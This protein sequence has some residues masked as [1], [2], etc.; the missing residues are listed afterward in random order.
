ML[1][2]LCPPLSS[3]VHSIGR[4]RFVG[5]AAELAQRLV[6]DVC[7]D[8]YE[9]V[10]RGSQVQKVVAVVGLRLRRIELLMGSERRVYGPVVEWLVFGEIR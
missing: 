6:R 9:T 4:L 3:L 7:G 8:W 10:V 2:Q 5:C 1:I